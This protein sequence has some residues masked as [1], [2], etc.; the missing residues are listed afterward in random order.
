MGENRRGAMS[1]FW[2]LPI[3]KPSFPAPLA[4]SHRSFAPRSNPVFRSGA[5]PVPYFPALQPL[6][7]M[8]AEPVTIAASSLAR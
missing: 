2:P 1:A 6:S 3:Y 4:P 7:T 8:K 5:K